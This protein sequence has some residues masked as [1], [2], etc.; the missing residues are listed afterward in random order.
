MYCVYDTYDVPQAFHKKLAVVKTYLHSLDIEK[1]G[2]YQFFIIEQKTKRID[3]QILNDLYL[4]PY[5]DTFI[6]SGYIEYIQIASDRFV[7]QAR[8]S[9]SLWLSISQRSD[10]SHKE[11]K[12]IYK[13]VDIL[14]N[15][16]RHD[17]STVPPLRE[18]KHMRD[19]YSEYLTL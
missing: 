16:Y 18:L 13:A 10:L 9:I 14:T 2:K 17:I 3:P 11:K 15:L 8:D 12:I 1:D 7:E 6:Q 4:V 19:M 5:G